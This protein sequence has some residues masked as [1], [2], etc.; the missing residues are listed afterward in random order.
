MVNVQ[1][2]IPFSGL[3]HD[4]ETVI[5]HAEALSV[6]WPGLENMLISDLSTGEEAWSSGYELLLWLSREIRGT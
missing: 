2:P 6:R 1:A 4:L 5:L 3:G